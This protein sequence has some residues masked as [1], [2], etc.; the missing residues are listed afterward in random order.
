[1][2]TIVLIHLG[3]CRD[4]HGKAS[5]IDLD[6]SPESQHLSLLY[7]LW[8]TS[9]LWSISRTRPRIELELEP[10]TAMHRPH[11]EL[12]SLKASKIAAL[13]YKDDCS[14]AR[15]QTTLYLVDHEECRKLVGV[16]LLS[17]FAC[18]S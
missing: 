11:T 14:T 5:Y 1:M 2:V 12:S 9:I 3:Y 16:L 18:M 8:K 7:E 4:Q 17:S 15:L 10:T 13:M 6:T